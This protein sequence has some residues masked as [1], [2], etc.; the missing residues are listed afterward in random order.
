M[1]E[2]MKKELR[3]KILLLALVGAVLILAASGCSLLRKIEVAGTWYD[4]AEF[5][6][7]KFKT[8]ITETTI[9]GYWDIADTE[10]AYVYEIVDFYQR[11]WNGGETGEGDTG[12]AVVRYSEYPLSPDLVG[13]YTVFRW[14]NL[15]NSNGV[16]TAEFSEGSPPT[17]PNGYAD[18]ASE[19]ED[20][21][22]EANGWF[23]LGYK[24]VTLQ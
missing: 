2:M 23:A 16:L 17:W 3:N 20:N 5:F 10:P 4:D 13:A 14:Q 8:V 15:M 12:Y 9:S 7:Q 21:A 24:G 22:T 1:E 11:T 19:A 6:G 18:T